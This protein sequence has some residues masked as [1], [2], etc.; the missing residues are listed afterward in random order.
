LLPVTSPTTA[1]N[2]YL[3]GAADVVWD[4]ELVPVELIDVLR[5]RPDFQSFN[6][7]ATYFFRFNLQRKP[8]DD[9]RVR[10]ALVLAIDKRHIVEKITRGNERVANGLVP[11]G[12]PNYASPP[13]LEYNPREA[14]RLLAEAGYPGGAGFPPFH[15]HFNNVKNQENIAVQIQAMWQRELGIHADLRAQEWKVYLNTQGKRDYDISRSSWI[16]DYNDPTTFLDL[17]MSNNPNNRTGWASTNYD[18]LMRRAAAE[19]D[20]A[21]RAG[22]LRQAEALLV[23]EEVPIVPIYFFAGL[24]YYNRA[25]VKG[26]FPNLRA[27]HPIRTIYKTA[28]TSVAGAGKRQMAVSASPQ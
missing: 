15:Y 5:Q 23:T 16:G 3:S 26:I 20:V 22:F 21:K 13:G 8:F 9:V 24:E 2:L 14:R 7:L 12:L 4:K 11:P 6:Y 17:F 19:P 18:K 27:E 25:S 28:A 1:L 10:K